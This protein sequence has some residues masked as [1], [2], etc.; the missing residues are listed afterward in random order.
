MAN[1][2]TFGSLLAAGCLITACSSSPSGMSTPAASRTRA[3]PQSSSEA[4]SIVPTSKTFLSKAYGY[5]VTVPAD[6]TPRQ[7]Y[8]KWDGE[9]ELD[10]DS[11]LVDLLGQPGETKGMFVAAAPT[12]RDLAADTA[13]AIT[14][15]AHYHGDYC[16]NRPT[17]GR[18]TVGG[19][20]GVLLA[21]NCGILVNHVVTV[22]HGVEY[23]FVFVDRGVD[24]A[25]DPT[26]HATFV[27][28]LSSVRFRH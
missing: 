27:K 7:A 23:W 8:A 14:F 21:Y 10:G 28:M 3:T 24:A 25:T 17:R 13:F 16:P 1:L 22:Y 15:N 12:K 26:D 20:P 4:G 11:A 5:T 9:S 6:F 19:Q 18:V 2:V